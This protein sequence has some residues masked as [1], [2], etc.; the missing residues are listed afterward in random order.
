[1]FMSKITIHYYIMRKVVNMKRVKVAYLLLIHFRDFQKL[2]LDVIANCAFGL[3]TNSVK[4][5]T[6]I[7]LRK[8]RGAFST[9]ENASFL[10]KK[11][12]F[13][14]LCMFFLVLITN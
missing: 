10:G 8:C 12:V 6:S 9:A 13:P 4:D 7:F 5:P 11:I 1:M 14:L 2:T 3:D